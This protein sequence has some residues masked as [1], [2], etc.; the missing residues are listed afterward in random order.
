M[1]AY[2]SAFPAQK[3]NHSHALTLHVPKHSPPL[4]N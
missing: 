4:K 3:R 1:N 2:Q